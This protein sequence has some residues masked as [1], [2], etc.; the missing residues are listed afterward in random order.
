[1][2]NVLLGRTPTMEEYENAVD[3][4]VLTKFSSPNKELST[5]AAS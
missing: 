1:M 3:G 2:S 4:I 5:I